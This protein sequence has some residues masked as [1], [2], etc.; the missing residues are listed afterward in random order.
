M[1]DNTLARFWSSTDLTTLMLEK[2]NRVKVVLLVLLAT[3]HEILP[4]LCMEDMMKCFQSV[5]F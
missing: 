1:L 2:T 5:K 3:I 4:G